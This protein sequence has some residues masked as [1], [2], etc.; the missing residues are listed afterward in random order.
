MEYY[1]KV[2]K[3]M[4]EIDKRISKLSTRI[5]KL[6]K[7]YQL[8]SNSAVDKEEYPDKLFIPVC[9]FILKQN[10]VSAEM[11][12]NNFDIGYARSAKLIDELKQKG[13]IE[14]I[15]G[16]QGNYKINIESLNKTIKNKTV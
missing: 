8:K 16:K 11:L 7:K 13:V 10:K 5:E 6:I 2:L 12:Q 14:F 3:K 15:K 4:D 9:E 1:D